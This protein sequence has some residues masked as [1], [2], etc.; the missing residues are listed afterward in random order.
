MG[1]ETGNIIVLHD[2]LE[3]KL[4]KVSWKEN[5]SA[6]YFFMLKV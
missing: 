2:D 5:G 1:I 4:G 6:G 3:R